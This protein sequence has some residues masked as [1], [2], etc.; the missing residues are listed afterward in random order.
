MKVLLAVAIGGAIGAIARFNYLNH[1]LKVLVR[2][3]FTI[4]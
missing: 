1:L 2:I 3:L 4:Y